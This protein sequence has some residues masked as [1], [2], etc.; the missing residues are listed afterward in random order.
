MIILAA[1]VAFIMLIVTL[2]MKEL[3]NKILAANILTTLIVILIVL[4]SIETNNNS[5]L[6]IAITFALLGFLGTQFFVRF[7]SGRGR[8]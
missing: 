7:L 5:Y 6:D 1:V 2:S 4:V 3:W 8:F